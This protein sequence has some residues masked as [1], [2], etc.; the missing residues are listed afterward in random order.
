[1]GVIISFALLSLSTHSCFHRGPGCLLSAMSF[2]LFIT[3][4]CI[5]FTGGLH[6][7]HGLGS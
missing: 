6:H 7:I 3:A 5:G 2:S 1:M 4:S